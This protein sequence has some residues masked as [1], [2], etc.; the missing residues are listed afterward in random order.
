[1]KKIL[2]SLLSAAMMT[3]AWS[4]EQLQ[5]TLDRTITLAQQQSPSAV[6]AQHSL[7]SAYWT[8]RYYLAN[9][10]PSVTLT[11]SPEFNRGIAQVVQP[12]GTNSFVHVSQVNS[13]VSLQI[14]QNIPLTGG[15]LFIN[16]SLM[17]KPD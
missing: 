5:L 6:A 4:Q 2:F 3:V 7:Q 12:D 13:D 1:M 15:S 17:R 10:K 14:T 11:T 9:Y 16:S 8:Y